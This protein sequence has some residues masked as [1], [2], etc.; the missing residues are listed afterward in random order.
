[1]KNKTLATLLT[2]VFSNAVIAQSDL[3]F[4]SGMEFVSRLNDTGITWAGEY[5]SGNLT[6]CSNPVSNPSAQ[7]CNTGRDV[8]HNDPTDGHAGFSFTKLGASGNTLA[9]QSVDYV[10]TP[11]A[12]VQDNVTGLVWE[13]KTTTAGIHNKDN[14]YRWGGDTAIGKGHPNA[15]GTYY[16]P[17]WNE[18]VQG[19]NIDNLCG[20]NNWRVPTVAELSSIVNKG[21]FNP[22]IDT[23]YFPNTVPSLFWSSSPFAGIPSIAW[24]IDFNYGYVSYAYRNN[25]G[26]VLLVRSGQ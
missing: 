13:V 10:T 3:I 22:A 19:S 7:D 23:N 14:T 17:S 5:P 21:T 26:R 16:D 6:G 1:M 11:W 12:C 20:Y 24:N 8:T 25:V 15:Q 4:K 9:D 2:F 18:L